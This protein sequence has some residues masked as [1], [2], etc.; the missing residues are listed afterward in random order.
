MG[1]TNEHEEE[2]PDAS[3]QSV[4]AGLRIRATRKK[5]TMTLKTEHGLKSNPESESQRPQCA[6]EIVVPEESSK[7]DFADATHDVTPIQ[8]REESE[9][10]KTAED[11]GMGT[12]TG[13]TECVN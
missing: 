5:K 8:V 10:T 9:V 12:G 1:L 11:T 7:F 3:S 6:P 2:D 13:T 4:P